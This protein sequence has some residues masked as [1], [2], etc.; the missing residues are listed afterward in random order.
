MGFRI[1]CLIHVGD[2]PSEG[3]KRVPDLP[4]P[5]TVVLSEYETV[6]LHH[7]EHFDDCIVGMQHPDDVLLNDVFLPAEHPQYRRPL[8]E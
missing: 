4:S 8:R 6:L 1:D 3:R 5:L 2:L 7:G